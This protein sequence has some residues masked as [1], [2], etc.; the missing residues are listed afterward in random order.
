MFFGIF[1][2]V[3]GQVLWFLSS[4][5]LL[6]WQVNIGRYVSYHLERDMFNRKSPE[7]KAKLEAEK[8]KIKD[9]KEEL[10]RAE[11]FAKSP[12]GKARAAKMAGAKIFQFAAPLSKTSADVVAMMGAFTSTKDSQHASILDTIEA[13]GW[14]LEHAGYVYRITRSTSRDKFL[15][16]GQQEAVEGEIIGIYIFRIKT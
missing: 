13:E 9:E 8:R 6:F 15:S 3:L 16:S 14:L 12:A 5:S 10:R 11:K 2:T 4:F 1:S 7:E